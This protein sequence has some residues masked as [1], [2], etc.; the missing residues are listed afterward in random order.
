[1]RLRIAEMAAEPTQEQQ[2]RKANVRLALILGGLALVFYL[3]MV[4]FKPLAGSL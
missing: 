2:T 1:M 4:F 3:V